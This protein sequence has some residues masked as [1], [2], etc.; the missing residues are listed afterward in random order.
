MA[1][2][3][4]TS[5]SAQIPAGDVY[6]LLQELRRELS[7]LR[8]HVANLEDRQKRMLDSSLN[9]IYRPK[10]IAERIGVHHHTV[11]TWIKEGKLVPIEGTKITG[12]ELERFLQTNG[13]Y[14]ERITGV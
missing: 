12:W 1:W 7:A 10:Q 11:L 3:A 14:A 2:P 9:T 13:R 4:T 8:Q 5:V 6:V